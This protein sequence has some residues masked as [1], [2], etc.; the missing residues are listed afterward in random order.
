MKILQKL[1]ET[2]TQKNDFQRFNYSRIKED[3]KAEEKKYQV[4]SEISEANIVEEESNNKTRKNL[5][6][7][8]IWIK[9]LPV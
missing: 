5:S 6:E 2:Q 8:F 9:I 7:E 3:N 4:S 1:L